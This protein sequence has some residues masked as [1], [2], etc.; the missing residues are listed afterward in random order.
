[1]MVTGQRQAKRKGVKKYNSLLNK[2]G[3]GIKNKRTCLKKKFRS[4]NICWIK[5]V[6][7]TD[8][9]FFSIMVNHELKSNVR[10]FYWILYILLK[11]T[12]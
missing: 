5:N 9:G 1:M 12:Y 4:E 3:Y 10:I 7:K 2:L 11:A 6:V 8:A